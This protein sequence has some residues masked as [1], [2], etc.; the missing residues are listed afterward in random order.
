MTKIRDEGRGRRALRIASRPEPAPAFGD[1]RAS[2]DEAAAPARLGYMQVLRLGF[3]GVVLWSILFAGETINANMR[4]VFLG[5]AIYA[6]LMCVMEVGRRLARRVNPTVTAFMLLVDTVFLTGIVLASG[7][8]LSPLR[9]LVYIHLIAATLIYSYK[10]GIVVALVDSI[11]LYGVYRGQQVGLFGFEFGDAGAIG[12]AEMSVRQSWVFN[13]FV[14]WVIAL[15][16]APFSSINEREL[17]RRKADLGV[18]AEM[19]N[20]MENIQDP[21]EIAGAVLNRICETFEF[22]RGVVLAVRGEELVLVAAHN[23]EKTA[24]STA[25]IDRLIDRAWDR[26]DPLLVSRLNDEEDPRLA[27]LM[28]FAKNL[29]VAPMYADGQPL[30]VLVLERKNPDEAV[31][32]RRVISMV[33][34]F[35]SHGALA[36]RKATLLQQVQRMAE[37]DALTGVANRRSFEQAMSRDVSRALRSHEE[38][39]LILVDLD[40]FKA[41]NDR[42]GH[43]AGDDVLRKVGA[44]L[45]DACRQSDTSARYGGEEFAVLLPTCR[46]D[47]ALDAAERI[48]SLIAQIDGPVSITASAGVATYPVHARNATELVEAAD[49]ALYESKR[50]GRNRTTVSSRK[51]LRVVGEEETA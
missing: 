39:T 41:L 6:A 12:E 26:H 38:L 40:H 9:F 21:Q 4:E 36:M 16:T 49:E 48:R 1:A 32:Q 44:V 15:A 51:L 33:M 13:T 47:E 18:L 25:H 17:R 20:E 23:V 22:G 29:L 50:G 28:P 43:Q 7:G 42:F 31:I 27:Q 37:T 45:A 30:G 5:T 8:T 34:Q 11:L 3:V 19:A 10:V 24:F 46:K 35:A 2:S 14:Y